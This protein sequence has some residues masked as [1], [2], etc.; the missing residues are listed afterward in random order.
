MA[1]TYKLVLFVALLVSLAA[2]LRVALTE[3]DRGHYT[4]DD[5]SNQAV[6]IAG[7]N[8]AHSGFLKLA[9]VP[10][11]LQLLTPPRPGET[12]HNPANEGYVQPGQVK[13][14]SL[15]GLSFYTHYPAGPDLFQGLLFKLGL[16]S[17]R[18]HQVAALLLS[19]TGVALAW[20]AL[21]ELVSPLA[22][23]A[24]VGA[25]VLAPSFVYYADSFREYSWFF[26]FR[27][28]YLWLAI[29]VFKKPNALP[30]RAIE[31][32]ALSVLASWFSFDLVVPA[33]ATG[34]AFF[35]LFGRRHGGQRLRAS[36]VWLLILAC[37]MGEA[38][39]FALHILK[40][41]ALFGSV[42][43]AVKDMYDVM[44]IRGANAKGDYNA[45]RHAAK[46][47]F[48]LQ[49]FFTL[50]ALALALAGW[51]KA[52]AKSKE[53]L[54]RA[55]FVATLAG[56]LIWQLGM[57]QHSMIH[58]FTYR[59]FDAFVALGVALFVEFSRTKRA[60]QLALACG[61]YLVV[62]L[63]LCVGHVELIAAR[64]AVITGLVPAESA[65]AWAC[66]QL[67]R[68]RTTND[69]QEV[70]A[71][72]QE[73]APPKCPTASAPEASAGWREHLAELAVFFR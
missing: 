46:L 33:L 29:R 20:F 70:V 31:F 41:A 14:D 48:G 32:F 22:A 50:P 47:I 35:F 53:P 61:V 17:W 66:T 30:R 38:V 44:L 24:G 34:L 16:D 19:L 2:S 56:A 68:L 4:G 59:H 73:F 49:W 26:V 1:K 71:L 65:S 63:A 5:Y 67:N 11:Q 8:F 43:A 21:R 52:V 9:G 72:V 39:G 57:R 28:L 10:L 55:F 23:A 6:Y 69:R 7:W 42:S 64:R 60:R 27:W 58:A 36:H 54:W 62:H 51:L 3:R 13:T 12:F 25:F 37:P 40:N 45:L 15:K 18:S